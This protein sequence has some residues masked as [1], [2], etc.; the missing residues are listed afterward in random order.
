MMAGGLGEGGDGGIQRDE[1]NLFPIAKLHA[2][3]A[4]PQKVAQRS[5]DQSSWASAGATAGAL[6]EYVGKERTTALATLPADASSSSPSSSYQ[7][8]SMFEYFETR[9][10]NPGHDIYAAYHNNQQRLSYEGHDFNEITP[11]TASSTLHTLESLQRSRQS[12]LKQ[13]RAMSDS[14][15][16]V[17][18]SALTQRKVAQEQAYQT[19]R[20]RVQ[21]QDDRNAELQAMF[22]HKFRAQQELRRQL[23]PR[24]LQ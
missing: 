24:I 17:Q 2:A 19:R 7:R 10:T 20:Q 22:S 5:N 11:L 6:V 3:T 18:Q 21:E 16:Q 1:K 15:L 9:S 4:G 14:Q 8:M 23:T 13:W 12:D